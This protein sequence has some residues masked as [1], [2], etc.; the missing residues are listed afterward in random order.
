ML[1]S[2]LDFSPLE[3]SGC[4]EIIRCGEKKSQFF[5]PVLEF[6]W[7]VTPLFCLKKCPNKFTEWVI[8]YIF[9]LWTTSLE[10]AWWV[11]II[12]YL[13]CTFAFYRDPCT[14][15][16]F[17]KWFEFKWAV[18]FSGM[19]ITGQMLL[20]MVLFFNS[21]ISVDLWLNLI[22]SLLANLSSVY[23]G[24]LCYWHLELSVFNLFLCFE[25]WEPLARDQED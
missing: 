3:V 22:F 11:F 6:F 17:S 4:R 12:Y 20:Y 14:W 25:L 1:V 16:L 13:M 23:H 5:C 9:I 7:S 19:R 10:I 18:V 15:K 24:K 2:I 21:L 8:W